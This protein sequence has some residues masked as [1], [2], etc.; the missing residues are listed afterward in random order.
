MVL[1]GFSCMRSA[2]LRRLLRFFLAEH[3]PNPGH[4]HNKIGSNF[5]FPH[6]SPYTEAVMAK[7]CPKAGACGGC[8]LNGIKYSKQLERKQAL[9]EDL[10][11]PFGPVASILGMSEPFFDRNKVQ[12]VFG[13]DKKGE[14]VSGIYREGTHK[15]IPVRDCMIEDQEA[16]AVLATIRDLVKSFSIPPYDEDSH[17]GAIRHVLIRRAV[18]TDQTLVVLV[19]G[20]PMFRPKDAF[21]RE[22]VRRH[23]SVK[24]VLLH[25]NNQ[26]TSMV[27]SDG[28][29]RTLYGE[30][31]IQDNLC[32][33][34]FRISARSFYQVN[35]TQAA[36]L[37]TIAM[38]MARF[39]G[40]ENVIDAYCGTGTIGLIA[41]SWGAGHV[42]GIELNPDA[43]EDA[44]F[45]ASLNNLQNVSFI[46]ADASVEM[47]KMAKEGAKVDVVFLDPPRSGSDERFLASLIRLAPKTVIYIS[48]NPETLARDLRYLTK[49]GPYKMLGAQPVDMF[50]QTAHIESC[51]LLERTS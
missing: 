44:V 40:N 38:R 46:C 7:M 36:K 12:S 37:Y 13:Y 18:A 27:L 22:I 16:D 19:S 4:V 24:T 28:P 32:N 9:V 11:L 45:N 42:T 3:L 15:L 30:G 34:S 29:I 41:S 43:V 20:S 48:C 21:V 10:L 47:K 6:K 5:T 51:V 25:I 33:L 26:D 23:P 50:P 17:T 1:L 49:M 14:I 39:K 35:A 8:A 31:F 2:L